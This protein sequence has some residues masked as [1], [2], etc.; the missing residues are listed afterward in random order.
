MTLIQ[1]VIV[2]RQVIVISIFKKS[3]YNHLINVEGKNILINLKTQAIAEIKEENLEEIL[4]VLKSGNSDSIFFKDLKYGGYL[5]DENHDEVSELEIMNNKYR[6][7][8][9]HISATIMP[10]FNCNFRCVYCY[11]EKKNISMT[12]EKADEIAGYL[13]DLTENKKSISIGWFGGEPLMNFSVVKYVNNKIKE[14]CGNLFSSSMTTNGYLL[15]NIDTS[16]FDDLKIRNMQI[17]LDGT[18]ETHD[19]YR[20]LLNGGSTF[21]VILKGIKKLISTTENLKITLRVNVGP[22]NYEKIDELL[23]NLSDLPKKR[24]TIYFRWIFQGVHTE[25][26]TFH[27]NVNNFRGNDSFDKLSSLYEKAIDKKIDI[28]LPILSKSSYCDLDKLNN[29]VIGPEGELYPCTVAVDS[30]N[31]FGKIENNKAEFEDYKYIK[32][33]SYSGFKNKK[34]IDCEI[35]PLCYGGCRNAA[36]NGHLGCPEEKND[37]NRFLTLWYKVKKFEKEKVLS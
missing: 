23:N 31:S 2:V 6:Y 30:K 15:N 35:L 20:P 3:K 19:K 8:D 27:N 24:F 29:L 9:K 4:G 11:E 33:T 16:I 10:T 26:Q 18:K 1:C 7:S 22:E 14:K 17:T 13:I 12:L 34:C 25:D 21:N 32:W 5:I 36:Y 28:M 37:L